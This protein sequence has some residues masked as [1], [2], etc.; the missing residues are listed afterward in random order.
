MVSSVPEQTSSFL[1]KDEYGKYV[2]SEISSILSYDK[3][4]NPYNPRSGYDVSITNAYAGIGGSVRYL[5]NEVEGNYY[6]ALTKKLV[7]VTTASIGYLKEIRGTRSVHRFA[8]G[9]DG[10]NM[11]GFDSYGVGPRDNYDNSIGGNKYWTLSFV[12]KAPLSSREIG[13]DGK[14]FLDFGS[15]WGSRY[16]KS[17]IKDSSAIRS[18]AGI[19]IEWARSPLGVP[20]SFVFGFPLKKQSFDE[21]QTFTLTGIM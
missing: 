17:K 19:A 13:I 5:K 10:V 1:M 7:F 8:L 2:C 9:G 12:V 4:D 18:S 3:T 11:R 14:V 21:K 15:A 16:E 6:R 20:L